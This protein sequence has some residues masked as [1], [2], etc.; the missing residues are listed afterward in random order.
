MNKMA[1]NASSKS[2]SGRLVFAWRGW[3]TIHWLFWRNFPDCVT[4][5][6]EWN[7]TRGWEQQVCVD[8]INT[9]ENV[10]GWTGIGGREQR[11]LSQ[12]KRSSERFILWVGFGVQAMRRT[13]GGRQS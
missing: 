11:T 3:G 8:P 12:K 5:G 13:S 1:L 4:Q 2:V 9:K 6:E 7:K 10:P